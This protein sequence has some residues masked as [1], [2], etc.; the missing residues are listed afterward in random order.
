[1]SLR[2]RLIIYLSLLHLAVAVFA[3]FFLWESH[4]PWILL[5]ESVLVVSFIAGVLISRGFSIHLDIVST[6]AK[7]I[8]ERDFTHTFAEVKSQ[9]INQLILLYNDMI[10]RLR[11]EKILLEEQHL[12]LEE[13]LNASP[14]AIITL[15]YDNKIRTFNPSFLNYLEINSKDIRGKG[16]A[17][18][19]S[20]L[21]NE[22]NKTEKGETR[23]VNQSHRRRFRCSHLQYREHGFLCSFYI[24]DE[25][26]KE[27]WDSEKTAYET[28]IRTL[29]HEVNNTVGATNSILKSCLNYGDQLNSDDRNDFENALGIAIERTDHL[30]NFMASYADVIRLPNPILHS[31]NINN[32][33]SKTAQLIQP[34]CKARKI[35]VKINMPKTSSFVFVD[36]VQFE[37]VLVNILKNSMEAIDKNGHIQILLK[38]EKDHLFLDIIDS[39]KG[40][41]KDIKEQIF[42][43]F[44]STKADGHGIGLTLVREILTRHNFSFSLERQEDKNTRFRIDLKTKKPGNPGSL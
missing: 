10:E 21:A 35:E 39:G 36:V 25:L 24:I 33:I 31:E 17:E 23:I 30:N 42:T 44:F 40:M 37:Q 7:F 15:D 11:K 5:L 4:R 28:L 43:P 27:L 8:R 6:G 29:S 9:D 19:S 34:E 18:I 1:M 2:T 14:T 20:T 16:L 38:K 22:L 3:V 12:F 26:T 13:V 41:D 32:V